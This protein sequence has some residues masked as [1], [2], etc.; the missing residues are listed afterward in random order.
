MFVPFVVY[1]C[2]VLFFF[3]KNVEGLLERNKK[4]YSVTAPMEVNPTKSKM[5]Y[6]KVHNIVSDV[7]TP[8]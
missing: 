8:T 3:M 5:I 2:S 6:I 4:N 7:V 1:V